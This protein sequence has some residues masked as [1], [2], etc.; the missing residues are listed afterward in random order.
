VRPAVTSL[1]VLGLPIRLPDLFAV[2][3]V[4]PDASSVVEFDPASPT[5]SRIADHKITRIDELLCRGVTLRPPRTW[6]RS[7]CQGGV[8][9]RSLTIPLSR[10][11]TCATSHPR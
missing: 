11:F 10:F 6:T 7:K 5:R 1:V 3:L 4:M 9:G 8:A 2:G